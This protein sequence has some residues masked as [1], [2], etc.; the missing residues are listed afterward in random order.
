MDILKEESE[1]EV[2]F[3]DKEEEDIYIF[4]NHI[5]DSDIID[6][7]SS[8]KNKKWGFPVMYKKN[9]RESMIMWR[10]WINNETH[11]LFTLFGMVDGKLQTSINDVNLNESNRSFYEQSLL[12]LRKKYKDK[13]DNG[14]RVAGE[15]TFDMKAMLANK[16]TKKVKLNYPVYI[17]RKIDGIR[18]LVRYDED[19][20]KYVY[21]SRT[22]KIFPYC[23]KH[24]NKDVSLLMSFL[25]SGIYLDGEMVIFGESN[26]QRFVSVF[27][28]KKNEDPKYKDVV[29]NIFDFATKERL[30]YDVRYEML[31]KAFERFNKEKE[32]KSRIQ[33]VECYSASSYDEIMTF[34]D[35]FV[36]EG[37]EG[38]IIRKIADEE[39]SEKS[40][41]QSVYVFSRTNNLLK[42]TRWISEEC[43]IFDISPGEGKFGDC[44][45]I[46]LIN[47]LYTKGESEVKYFKVTAPG[48]FE[49]KEEYLK[50]KEEYIGK[51]LTVKYKSISDTGVFMK[52]IG[53]AIR[54]YE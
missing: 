4:E 35:V 10:A 17:Q 3:L 48:S 29:Y 16:L 7:I 39:R 50:N 6:K 1:Y 33:L 22:N 26:F 8:F 52:P 36:E 38:V 54:D 34:E 19:T 5:S 32:G 9:L 53:V 18:C 13:Y 24:F 51:M 14:Y 46:T 43:E 15:K 45:I 42:F 40:I 23:P 2:N 44:G 37:Y 20:D 49:E 28:S 31:M 11:Q 21:L 27:L 47:P 30:S 12:E 41:D 25:P